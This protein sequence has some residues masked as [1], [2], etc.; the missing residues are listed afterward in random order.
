MN[1]GNISGA[2]TGMD[3]VDDIIDMEKMTQLNH[4]GVGEPLVPL[5]SVLLWDSEVGM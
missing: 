5:S 3:E 4:S 2:E 1:R